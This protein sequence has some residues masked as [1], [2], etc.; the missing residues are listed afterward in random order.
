MT[1]Q[2]LTDEEWQISNELARALAGRMVSHN[3]VKQSMVYSA[4]YSP[5]NTARVL[6]DWLH[7]LTQL[8]ETFASGKDIGPERQNLELI[9]LPA[10]KTHPKSN[11]TLLLG[12]VARLMLFYAPRFESSKS[13]GR[14][15]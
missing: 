15:R 10:L 12:W 2:Q 3:L 6:I 8:G 14:R 1:A 5:Q 13:K 4:Q 11:W 7:R 9:L